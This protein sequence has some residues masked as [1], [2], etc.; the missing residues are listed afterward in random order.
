[1]I[2]MP[3]TAQIPTTPQSPE[4]S[5]LSDLRTLLIVGRRHLHCQQM[6]QAE[7]VEGH[8]ELAL[9]RAAHSAFMWPVEAADA[10]W[11]VFF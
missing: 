8:R 5:W 3:S 7:M 4:A 6:S 10:S 1:L 9:R 11:V 2:M